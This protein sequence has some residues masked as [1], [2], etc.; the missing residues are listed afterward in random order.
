MSLLII[1]DQR[2]QRSPLTILDIKT[3]MR[4]VWIDYRTVFLQIIYDCNVVCYG[5][6]TALKWTY[7]PVRLQRF[8]QRM[9]TYEKLMQ[10]AS[11]R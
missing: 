9:P 3:A 10:N 8:S 4:S 2:E 11:I 6:E 7:G 1:I 5:T